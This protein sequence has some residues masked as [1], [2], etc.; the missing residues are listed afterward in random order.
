MHVNH[1]V[2]SP[3]QRLCRMATHVVVCLTGPGAGQNSGPG[4]Q[5]GEG[6]LSAWR[7]KQCPMPI[8]SARPLRGP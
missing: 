8:A 4:A 3:D 7:T 2:E 1:R 6:I 5:P